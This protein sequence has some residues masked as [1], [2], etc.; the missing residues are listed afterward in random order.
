MIGRRLL[1]QHI[2]C[3]GSN[4]EVSLLANREPMQVDQL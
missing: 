3:G 4:F 2:D 1:E